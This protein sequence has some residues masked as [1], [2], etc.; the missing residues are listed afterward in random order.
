MEHATQQ[1]QNIQR[2]QAHIEHFPNNTIFWFMKQ[3]LNL[4]ES[5]S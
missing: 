1:K 5:K 4:K 3:N 2:I